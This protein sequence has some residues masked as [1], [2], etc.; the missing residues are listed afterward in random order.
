M[1]RPSLP[2]LKGGDSLVT[3]LIEPLSHASGPHADNIEI[4]TPIAQQE[5][6]QMVEF[7]RYKQVCRAAS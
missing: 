6:A 5:L 7:T 1:V 4:L 3:L 2:E